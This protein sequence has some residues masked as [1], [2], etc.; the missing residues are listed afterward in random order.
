MEKK[1]YITPSQ[2]TVFLHHESMIANS[3]STS[4]PTNINGLE[5]GGTA[6]AD[7]EAGVKANVIEWDN[8]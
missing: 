6:N 3:L 5:Y 4:N 7:D 8:W 1:T 2:H